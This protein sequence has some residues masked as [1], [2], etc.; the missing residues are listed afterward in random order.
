[1]PRIFS[2][3]VEP[4]EYTQDLIDNVYC[5]LGIEYAYVHSETSAAP[6]GREKLGVVL[7]RKSF[8]SRLIYLVRQLI[9][10]DVLI[11][12]GYV[13]QTQV[14]CIMLNVLFFRKPFAIESDTELRVP[15]SMLKRRLK[16]AWLGFLFSRSYCYGFPAGRY[17]HKELFVYY[18]M[19]DDRIIVMPMV[20]NGGKFRKRKIPRGDGDS[21]N[22]GVVGRLVSLK[23]VDKVI[24]AFANVIRAV[25]GGRRCELHIIGDGPECCRLKELAE[26][27]GNVHF[28][29]AL[30]GEEKIDI[31]SQLDVVILFSCHD[32][33]GFV[34]N[35]ALAASC[36]VI[37]S[38]GVGCRHELVEKFVPLLNG[39][40][41]APAPIK[42]GPTGYVCNRNDCEQLAQ[43][44]EQL[45]L[46]VV[47]H[48]AM[49][50]NASWRS[51]Y[52]SLSLYIEQFKRFISIVERRV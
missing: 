1:M 34:V 43:R 49:S 24:A 14:L 29:G 41:V 25:G 39:V 12:N 17:K 22:F 31:Y 40:D 33:W 46:D 2:L 36:P 15:S 32:Q 6:A 50:E 27:I 47:G 37:V 23:Q 13:G 51:E 52:W 30:Y 8:L 7:S 4:A 10:H 48:R 35:E 16:K 5:P 42:M 28:H 38:D 44:M 45:M 18:G 11:V 3:V 9:R 26:G 19:P 21:F 20:V